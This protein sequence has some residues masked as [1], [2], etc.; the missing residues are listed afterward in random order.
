MSPAANSY[1][2]FHPNGPNFL[3]SCKTACRK[4]TPNSSLRHSYGFEHASKKSFSNAKYEPATLV[5]KP[6][7]GSFTILAPSWST[8]TGKVA[9]GMLVSQSRK[10]R[11]T[12]SGSSESTKRSSVSIQLVAKWQFCSSTHDPRSLPSVM[13][14]SASGPWPCPSEIA[15]SF[16]PKPWSSANLRK[17]A[18]GSAPEEST[19]MS[20]TVAEESSNTL[21]R[22]KGGDS[23]KRSPWVS[24]TVFW[25]AWT[26]LSGRSAR[27]KRHF[28]KLDHFCHTPGISS[29][30]GEAE[31]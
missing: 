5:R 19:K 29:S 14:R 16:F 4:Q 1:K 12:I 20:G 23:M 18:V 28:W 7:G 3:R 17:I 26:H 6:F 15:S 25:M 10:S 30:C 22:S 13:S 27:R 21:P 31:S 9:L 24:A 2:I 11:C 8:E